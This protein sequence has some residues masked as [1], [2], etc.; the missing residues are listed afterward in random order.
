MRIIKKEFPFVCL[1]KGSMVMI[2]FPT[3][4]CDSMFWA[5]LVSNSAGLLEKLSSCCSISWNRLVRSCFCSLISLQPSESSCALDILSS[6][7]K[8]HMCTLLRL[9][10]ADLYTMKM[11]TLYT[12]HDIFS[13]YVDIYGIFLYTEQLQS[14]CMSHCLYITN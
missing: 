11:P 14:H 7:C 2:L 5:I 12:T 9:I 4:A 10:F 13:P 3:L 8:K 1:V 6:I